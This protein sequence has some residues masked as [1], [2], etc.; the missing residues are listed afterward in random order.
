MAEWPW[1]PHE[2]PLVFWISLVGCF[3]FWLLAYVL[4]IRRGFL[5]KTC[6]MPLAA[7][8]CNFGWEVLFSVVFLVEYRLIHYGTM[9]WC[10]LDVLILITALKYARHEISQPF[11]NKFCNWGMLAGIVMVIGFGIAFVR[12]Y[13]DTQG[14]FLGW[15]AALLMSVLFIAMLMRRD[16]VRGQSL[17]IASAMLLG[18]FFAFLW[19]KYIPNETTI[20]QQL[21]LV[22]M[23]LTVFFNVIYIALVYKKLVSEGI[24]PWKRF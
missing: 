19:V 16:S 5:E 12:A 8:C 24:N 13:G 18:N 9:A 1:L 17:Y 14:Y 20:T 7:L 22:M 4:I 11:L 21:N 2:A 23:L 6:G 3:G 15:L 10:L